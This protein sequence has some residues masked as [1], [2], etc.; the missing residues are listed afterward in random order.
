MGLSVCGFN[1][2]S[3]KVEEREPFQLSRT[4]LIEAAAHYKDISGCEEVVVVG[5]CNRVEFYQYAS[6]KSEQ[7]PSV[8]RFYRERGNKN[9]EK[10]R[11]LCYCR[12]K[13]TAARHLFRVASGLDSLVL[14]EDQVFHQLKEAYSNACAVDGPGKILHK[15]FHMAFKVGKRVRSE[16]NIG[17]GPRSVAG[18]AIEMLKNRMEDRLPRAALVCGVNEMTEIALD[19]FTRWGVPVYL[20][21]RSVEKAH[22]LATA[23]R[24]KSL[25]LGAVDTVLN[26]VDVIL[27]ATSATE[28]ILTPDQFREFK[29]GSHPLYLV[30]L[31][32]PRDI[33]PELGDFPG[34]VL[35]DLQ[36]MERYLEHSESFRA[37]DIPLAE[38]IISE[39]VSEY[40]IWRAKL[41]QE[42]KILTMHRE[43]NKLRKAELER[44]KEGFH[45]SEYRALN[46]FSQSLVR[47]FMRLLPEVLEEGELSEKKPE[48]SK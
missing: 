22:K 27:S 20:A 15:L 2:K 36:D 40:S 37:K 18:A 26:D 32:V 4:D 23:F 38:V 41:Q 13:T 42:E 39:Q 17:S 9:A 25:A 47:S 21:N 48:E 19:G 5:T 8:I 1:H 10:L 45:L 43:L 33:A 24:A 6:E 44:F 34:L 14:G 16:T 11:E 3:A 46:A 28:R 30:D 35:L 12:Q 7:L 31:A 29:A